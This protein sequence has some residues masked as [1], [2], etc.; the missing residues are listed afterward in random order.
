ML[1]KKKTNSSTKINDEDSIE[2]TVDATSID[3]N[4]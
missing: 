4:G 3:N 1:S 2:Q